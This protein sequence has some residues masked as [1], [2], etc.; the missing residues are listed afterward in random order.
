MSAASSK[1]D[2]S[3]AVSASIGTGRAP[4]ASRST[5]AEALPGDVRAPLAD[6]EHAPDRARAQPLEHRGRAASRPGAARRAGRRARRSG[7]AASCGTSGR[8]RHLLQEVVRRVAAVDVARRDLRR[9]QLGLVDRQRAPVVRL[10]R[11]AGERARAAPR[12]ARR[13]DPATPGSRLEHRLAVEAQVRGRTP[14]PRRTAR[15]RPRSSRRRGRRRAPGR[16]RAARAGS[17]RGRRRRLARDRDRA[18]ERRDRR[19]ERLGA[20]DARGDPAR[21]RARG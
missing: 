9:L 4:S 20:L 10:A 11:D 21:R 14:R 8:L 13:P 15:S 17:G 12:R 1:P 5:R 18:L 6:H 19:A 16:C 7:R 3:V 2:S